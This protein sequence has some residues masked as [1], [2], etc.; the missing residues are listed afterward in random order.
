LRRRA[1]TEADLPRL[2]YT[3]AVFNEAMRLFPP[4]HAT[5]RVVEEGAAL[6]VRVYGTRWWPLQ[7]A[8]GSASRESSAVRVCSI[9]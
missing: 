1:P 3:E 8:A 6:Q 5:T 2:T 9:S 4:A 7:Q